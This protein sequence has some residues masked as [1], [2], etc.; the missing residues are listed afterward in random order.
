MTDLER[1]LRDEERQAWRRLVRVL[2]HEINNSLAPIKSITASVQD[3]IAKTGAPDWAADAQNGLAIVA[4]RAESL[5]RF[6]AS[7]ARLA[8]LPPPSLAEVDVET[9]VRHVAGLETRLQVTVRDGESMRIAADRD[10]L[11][12]AL[13]NLVA[14]AVDATLQTGGAVEVYW[15]REG[16]K[17]RRDR[18]RRGPGAR[19]RGQP[20]R[21][22]LYDQ[23]RRLRNRPGAQPAH[24]REPRRLA[25]AREPRRRERCACTPVF[26]DGLMLGVRTLRGVRTSPAASRPASPIAGEDA[27]V[28]ARASNPGRSWIRISSDLAWLDGFERVGHGRFR[29][30]E[31]VVVLQVHPAIGIR[32][33]VACEAKS[34]FGRDAPAA[35]DDFVDSCRGDPDR[36]GKSS[37]RK[38]QRHHEVLL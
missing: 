14:N 29:Q 9:W 23:A 21:A 34:G 20:I 12:Q 13:I 19:G 27:R 28:P 11:D 8:R 5:R 16:H 17:R 3:L 6:L 18:R 26:A 25:H 24:R 38:A 1:T 33:E 22:V 7:Y 4:T 31:F 37:V 32:A 15:R 30:R 35:T 36:F 10:Q 2:S